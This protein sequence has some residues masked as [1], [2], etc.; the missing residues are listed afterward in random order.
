MKG[1]GL[2]SL[3]FSGIEMGMQA[4]HHGPDSGPAPRHLQFA[5]P[6]RRADQVHW[7]LIMTKTEDKGLGAFSGWAQVIT[8]LL[9]PLS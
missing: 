3:C 9:P 4:T 5:P 2:W 1:W 6:L 7:C 8:H